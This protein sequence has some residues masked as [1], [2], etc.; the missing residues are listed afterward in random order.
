MKQMPIFNDWIKSYNAGD[1]INTVIIGLIPEELKKYE[2]K[3]NNMPFF[4]KFGTTAGK[5]LLAKYSANGFCFAL[6]FIHAVSN[7]FDSMGGSMQIANMIKTGNIAGIL[8]PII[9]II[10]IIVKKIMSF[11]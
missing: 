8:S 6:K 4:E 1:L 3:Y 2:C 5:Y 11:F 10:I 7:I 9:L